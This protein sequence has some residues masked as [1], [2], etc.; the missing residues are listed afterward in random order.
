MDVMLGDL[1]LDGV[2]TLRQR[3]VQP[4]ENVGRQRDVLPEVD[5]LGCF[6]R[7]RD[8]LLGGPLVSDA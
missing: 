5:L 4:L 1:V 6:D 2:L 7:Q 3:D 8:V